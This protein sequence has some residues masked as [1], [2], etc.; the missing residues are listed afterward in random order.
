[1]VGPRVAALRGVAAAHRVSHAGRPGRATRPKHL[2]A[3]A[4]SARAVL[5]PLRAAFPRHSVA[6][7]PRSSVQATRPKHLAAGAR[8]P[9]AEAAAPGARHYAGARPGPQ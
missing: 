6:T 1:M 2:V 7:L 9:P 4:R 3:G 5:G 8:P